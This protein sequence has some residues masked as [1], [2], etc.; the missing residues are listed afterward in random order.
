MA[1]TRDDGRKTKRGPRKKKARGIT[2]DEHLMKRVVLDTFWHDGKPSFRSAGQVAEALGEVKGRLLRPQPVSAILHTAFEKKKLFSVQIHLPREQQEARQLEDAVRAQYGLR[3]VLLVPGHREIMNDLDRERRRS[4]HQAIIQAMAPCAAAV[5]DSLVTEAAKRQ[6][7]AASANQ[8]FEPWRLGVAWGRT[9]HLIARHLLS[10]ERAPQT[11][12]LEVVPI[13]GI[14]S[15]RNTLGVEANVVAMD[16]ARAYGGYSAQ[17]PCPAFVPAVSY[18]V[19]RQA[20][21]VRQMLHTIGQ[22]NAVITSMG[23]ILEHGDDTDMTLSNNP[24]LNADLVKAARSAG[25]IGEVCFCLFDRN[26]KEV[27]CSHRAIGLT[28]EGFRAIAHDSHRQ[29]IL[30]CGGDKRRLEPLKVALRAGLAS[31]LVSDTVTARHLVRGR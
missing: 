18:A 31:V 8:G 25:A 24:K 22:C 9:L 23:P 28:F 2:Q 26:G 13:I 3:K 21:E 12:E 14:T 30:V 6:C 11:P 29:V 5:L 10:T 16:V 4:M 7:A 15:T 17:L 1:S 19:A 20:P 27:R